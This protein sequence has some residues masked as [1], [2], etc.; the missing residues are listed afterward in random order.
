MLNT[1]EEIE[2]ILDNID[3]DQYR[4]VAVVQEN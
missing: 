4:E 1:I 3:L 2:D